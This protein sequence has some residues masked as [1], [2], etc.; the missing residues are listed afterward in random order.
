M[1]A[2]APDVPGSGAPQ[3]Q[4]AQYAN[5]ALQLATVGVT[6]PAS[7]DDEEAV[8]LWARANWWMALPD[9]LRTRAL[10]EDWPTVFGFSAFQVDQSIVIGEPP[11]TVTIY[12]GRF[13]ADE[14]RAAWTAT[15]YAEVDI[16]GAESY[17]LSEDG[18]M[19]LSSPVGQLALAQM[20]NAAILP[21]GTLLFSPTLEQLRAMVAAA[22]GEAATLAERPEVASLMAALDPTVISGYVVPGNALRATPADLLGQ[23]GTPEQIAAIEEQLA[24]V[25]GDLEPMPH[26]RLA[27]ITI[28]AGGPLPQLSDES[29]STPMP[30]VPLAHDLIALV[31]DDRAAAEAAIPI[32]EA[33][34]KN[35]M[36][37]AT[38]QPY[39]D[40]FS[41]WELSVAEKRL[42]SWSI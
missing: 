8:S 18:S 29:L 10:L 37:F 30:D 14:L 3:F 1:L 2:L 21:D 25:D 35:G 7:I 27:A 24:E 41:D 9:P 5:P 36:S 28:T 39:S 38:N 26:P 15:G 6:P 4:I 31:M 40:F 20:N 19:D 17:S 12:R 32:V 33:R 13:D 34:L 23:R 16:D 42:C 11:A 22:L